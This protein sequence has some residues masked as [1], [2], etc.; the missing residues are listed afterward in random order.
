MA[1]KIKDIF[2][3]KQSPE[4][5]EAQRK[6]RAA[7]QGAMENAILEFIKEGK[8][9]FTYNPKRI[10]MLNSVRVTG[11]FFLMI[12]SFYCI[13]LT[14]YYMCNEIEG[15]GLTLS[16]TLASILIACFNILVNI[17]EHKLE[18]EFGRA[19]MTRQSI[20]DEI[21]QRI[22]AN[23]VQTILILIFPNEVFAKIPDLYLKTSDFFINWNLLAH[24]IQLNKFYFIVVYFLGTSRYN[25][26]SSYRVCGMYEV[27][28]DWMFVLKAQFKNNP[29]L[30][31]IATLASTIYIFSYSIYIA[32]NPMLKVQGKNANISDFKTSVWMVAVT[33][34]TVGYGDVSPITKLGKIF[35][36][37]ACTCGM[38]IVSLIITN[39]TNQLIL[40]HNEEMAYGLISKLS[41]Y[42]KTEERAVGLFTHLVKIFKIKAGIKTQRTKM[43]YHNTK[44]QLEILIKEFKSARQEYKY[45][46]VNSIDQDIDRSFERIKKEIVELKFLILAIHKS[47]TEQK[48]LRRFQRSDEPVAINATKRRF[49]NQL[50]IEQCEHSGTSHFKHAFSLEDLP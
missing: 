14:P 29:L 6:A 19:P 8:D 17:L 35:V 16:L 9:K 3:P 1:S 40:A 33:I 34:T 2:L 36:F 15:G 20:R 39:I 18:E 11:E 13:V 12:L 31:L 43:N 47:L 44:E 27:N 28:K 48:V 21:T 10:E 7:K 42:A 46:E 26:D 30:L 45:F 23:I 37:F 32:E 25:S 24:V 22:R 5:I 50:S 49:G 38:V 41:L 4:Q